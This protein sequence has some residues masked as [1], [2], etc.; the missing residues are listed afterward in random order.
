MEPREDIQHIEEVL[1]GNTSAFAYLVERYQDMVFTIAMKILQNREDAEEI[2]Q[3]AFV[4]AYNNLGSFRKESRFSTWLYRIAYN[5]AISKTRLK[6]LP[7]IELKEEITRSLP[8]DEI[9]EEVKGLDRYEQKRAVNLIMKNLPEG[10][11]LLIRLY[12]N[13]GMRVSE[14]GEVMGM[15]ESNVKV[16]LHRLRKKI[17]KELDVILSKKMYSF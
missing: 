4:K 9:E 15:S 17:Y 2:A 16:R 10:D 6:K 13:E 14:I 7:E 11:Q 1:N 8:E 12:Y 3:D 5:E